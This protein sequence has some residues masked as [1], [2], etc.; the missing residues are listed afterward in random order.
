MALAPGTRIGACEIQS[1][2]GAGGMGEVYRALD[3]KLGRTVALKV[4]PEAFAGDADRLARFEREA[5]T[6]ATLN[7]PHI[8]QIYGLEDAGASRAL[9]M[10]L[11]EG[12]DLSQRLARGAI[13]VD[14][15][16]RMAAQIAEAI[17]VAH[18][19]GVIHRDLKPANIRVTP[20]GVVKVLD[21]GLAKAMG[22]PEGDGFSRRQTASEG[23]GFSRRLA[24]DAITSP[25]MTMRGMI[26]GTAAYMSPEQAQGRVAD[27]RSDVWA[28]GCVLY[29]MLT[30]A[31]A[32]KGTDI[33]DTLAAVMRSEPDWQAWPA[34]VPAPVQALV[35]G[36]LTKNRRDRVSDIAV[37]RYAL[38]QLAA[39]PSAGT[40]SARWSERP[41]RERWYAGAAGLAVLAAVV[42]GTLLVRKPPIAPPSVVR[43]SVQPAGDLSFRPT[44]IDRDFVLT[45]DGK[46]IVYRTRSGMLAVRA[47]DQF[48]P[49]LLA[50]TYNAR[51]PFVSPD[52]QWVGYW[53]GGT[54]RKVPTAGGVRE[55]IAPSSGAPRGHAWA[56]DD[57]I[58]FASND[59]QG[60]RRVP[61][62]G[63]T[64]E[65]L[66]TLKPSEQ[67]HWFPSVIPGGRAVLF[68]ISTNTTE[69]NEVA[70]YDLR[71]GRQKVLLT[72]GTQ[73]VYVEPGYLVFRAGDAMRAVAFDADRLEVHGAAV[74]VLDQVSSNI[75]RSS[76]ADISRNGDLVF[77]AGS[78][79]LAMRSLVW[80]DRAGRVTKIPGPSK[81]YV[82]PRVSPDGTRVAVDV[83]DSDQDIWVNDLQRGTSTRLTFGSALDGYPSWTADGRQIVFASSAETGA[84]AV[85]QQAADGTGRPQRIATGPVGEGVPLSV[86]PGGRG[87][88][89]RRGNHLGVLGLTGISTTE[90]LVQT[91][92]VELSG[93]V[94]PDGRWL[95]YESTE[96]GR[97]EVYVRPFPNVAGGRWQVSNSGGS[98][99]AWARNGR[100][101]FYEDQ[102]GGLIA[103]P[104]A[105]GPA[106]SAGV[107]VRLFDARATLVGGTTI[108]TWD[109]APD[110]RF[111]MVQDDGLST[112]LPLLVVLNWIEELKAKFA[113]P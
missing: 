27:K 14:E 54:L 96:S 63:G 111:L 35:R 110:G 62:K 92:A 40:S 53:A 4:L 101:L 52:G 98:R 10:E 108:R 44:G 100:E 39:S 113:V 90:P 61:A 71:T 84:Q 88:L 25:A 41:A 37:A 2:I 57:S 80:V 33:V 31:R 93:E 67:G 60:L 99:P 75:T 6:L 77:V 12:E 32:F 72:G 42:L 86:I 43:L 59:G 38:Q 70:A 104:V 20:D 24:A 21:F 79:T 26:L 29:E 73:P 107:A 49:R 36:C 102:D 91:N 47:L 103:V 13:P 55:D 106:F 66:T 89:M 74:V 19:Q 95:A 64:P 34:D 56:A 51:S 28:F 69:R 22:P 23:D 50:G 85:Y 94:S 15:A 8:A 7:H 11:V 45:P 82:Y 105:P 48:E 17:E 68:T 58:Y 83:R 81:P 3:T 87:I 112:S 5:R 46:S 18:E 78:S 76:N 109:V 65:V 30:G 16:L 9:I 1:V 97:P